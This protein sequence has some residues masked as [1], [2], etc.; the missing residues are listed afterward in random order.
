[1]V[2]AMTL[3]FCAAWPLE[4]TAADTDLNPVTRV[5]QLLQ[6]LSKK[7]YA[8]GKAEEDLY[9]KFVCWGESIINAKT[10]SNAAAQSRIDELEAYIADVRSG[11]VEFTSERVSLEQ[12]VASFKSDIEASEAQRKKEKADYLAAKD[13]IEKAVKALQKALKVLQ[14]ATSLS[15]TSSLISLR[16]QLRENSAQK[17]EDAAALDEAIRLGKNFLAKG[18]A[19]FLQRL[20]TGDVPE[21]D[22]KKLNRK[23]VFKMKYKARSF[24]I[25]DV[26]VNL[27]KTFD[28]NLIAL[29][30]KEVKA[31]ELFIK[32]SVSM[33]GQLE[34]AQTGLQEMSA[35]GAAQGQTE[36]GAQEE[37]DALKVQVDTDAQFIKQTQAVLA[38]KKI[39]WAH[40]QKLRA[41]ELA[42]ISKAIAILNSDEARDQ[43]QKSFASQGYLLLQQGSGT[44]AALWQHVVDA[45]AVIRATAA[46]VGDQRLLALMR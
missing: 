43:M 3:L 44:S 22:W 29:D 18:D 6:E 13:E 34:T 27:L 37:V 19:E 42:A 2:I 5:V 4:A 28:A 8:D 33:K 12:A 15:Q 24:K 32:L 36:E 31:E 9:E 25:Q 10:A 14:A 38:D 20:L 39:E 1:M 11:K 23:A 30:A 46:K 26:L 35:E 41:E 17:A 16:Q 7:I 40:R 45:G 21:V